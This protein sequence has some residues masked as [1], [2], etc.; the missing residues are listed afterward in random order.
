MVTFVTSRS[1]INEY[2]FSSFTGTTTTT[3]MKTR[4]NSTTNT[5]TS[6]NKKQGGDEAPTRMRHQQRY[7]AA[8]YYP[9]IT[10]HDDL[11][12]WIKDYIKFHNEHIITTPT[13][14]I[15]NVDE[16]GN[17][18]DSSRN[19]T[20]TMVHTLKPG[21]KYLQYSC[22]S[23]CGGVGDRMNGIMTLFY[24][25]IVTKRVLLI[26]H[27]T[28][29]P[30]TDTLLPNHV[31]WDAKVS[32]IPERGGGGKR[33]SNNVTLQKQHQNGNN[34]R[35]TVSIIPKGKKVKRYRSI[36]EFLVDQQNL[37]CHDD[38]T[39]EGIII[40]TNQWI[41]ERDVIWNNE[42]MKDMTGR[43]T[44]TSMSSSNN[45]QRHHLVRWSFWTL[46]RFNEKVLQ[47]AEDMKRIAGLDNNKPYIGVH[48]RSERHRTEESHW[49]FYNCSKKFQKHILALELEERQ[50]RLQQQD[51]N[52]T[53]EYTIA[54][55]LI[56]I[57]DDSYPDKT[58][59]S[60]PV[61]SKIQ[62]WDNND[63]VKTMTDMQV[64]HTELTDTT[65]ISNSYQANIDVYA[66]LVLL[67]DSECLM[68][69]RSGFSELPHRISFSNTATYE[70]CGVRFDQCDDSDVRSA[71]QLLLSQENRNGENITAS[72]TGSNWSSWV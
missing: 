2:Y 48:V 7:T 66:E 32:G 4:T 19:K 59:K 16:D 43:S 11:P 15:D 42:C 6:T 37:L 38:D 60:I 17:S 45:A 12:Y 54:P 34:N 51:N 33:T 40:Q 52:Y 44:T 24:V 14:V 57:A 55:R 29:F 26:D 35:P 25:A 64:I 13:T 47:R 69:S 30:L 61:K 10:N 67:I 23:W 68:R 49:R 65:Q 5:A 62:S 20:L 58:R 31:R 36:N 72:A 22:S 18:D 63:T 39:V 9:N 28:P 70:R 8:H 46:F 1:F 71:T 56:Y 53:D 50:S 21:T 27:K 41:G 3:T